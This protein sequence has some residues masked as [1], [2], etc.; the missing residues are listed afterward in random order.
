LLRL[1]SVMTGRS[2][3]KRTKRNLLEPLLAKLMRKKASRE[4]VLNESSTDRLQD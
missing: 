4:G 3:G 1:A 2:E